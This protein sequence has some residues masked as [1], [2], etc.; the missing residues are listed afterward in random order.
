MTHRKI[1]YFDV[2]G[3]CYVAK[4]GRWRGK[5]VISEDGDE[6]A[7]RLCVTL[8]ENEEDACAGPQVDEGAGGL[9]SGRRVDG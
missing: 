3:T 5:Y 4:P 2:E 8:H 1:G 6:L 7:E 9:R